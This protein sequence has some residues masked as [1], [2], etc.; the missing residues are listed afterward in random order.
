[1]REYEGVTLDF[2]RFGVL[3]PG[4]NPWVLFDEIL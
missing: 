2:C 4:I 3:T 1:M